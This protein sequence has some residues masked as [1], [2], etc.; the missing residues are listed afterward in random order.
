MSELINT[1]TLDNPNL[2]VPME[3]A[4]FYQEQQEIFQKT[5]KSTKA[6]EVVNIFLFNEAGQFILQ[7]RSSTKAHNPN[8]ID[9]S[10]WW[11]IVHGDSPHFTVMLE[12]VQ[13]LQVPSIVANNDEDFRKIHKLLKDHMAT[14]A[15][16]KYFWT[17]LVFLNKIINEKE[18]AIG[19]KTHLY[20]WVYE[21]SVKNVD[22]EAKG[23]LFYSFKELEEEL[24]QFPKI[25]TYD[26][27]Y[28]FNKYKDY[29][30]DFINEIKK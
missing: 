20:I 18:I 5:W 14:T 16:V 26:L 9:K 21:W 24:S 11:H 17:E 3:R 6:V 13:E 27:H 22:R 10:V 15:I 19:N 8:L 12:T 4:S 23:V 25:F 29:F 7:K 2:V 1:I 30:R 28:Y